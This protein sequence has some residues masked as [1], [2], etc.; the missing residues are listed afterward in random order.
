M[1]AAQPSDYV[2]TL[3]GEVFF[4]EVKSTSDELTFHFSNIRRG[5]WNASRRITRAGGK[6]LF[7][8]KSLHW[9]QWYCVP[10]QVLHANPTK[11]M[12]WTQLKDYTYEL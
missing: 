3:N 5:Q 12:R 2:V 1:I 11:S 4:A 6:Y 10:A 9:D 8:I 7:F